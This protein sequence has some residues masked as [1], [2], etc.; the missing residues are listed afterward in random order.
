MLTEFQ[1]KIN[2]TSNAVAEVLLAES[3]ALPNIILL[4][5]LRGL[6]RDLIQQ[7]EASRRWC[8]HGLAL[9]FSTL[10]MPEQLSRATGIELTDMSII[11][12]LAYSILCQLTVDA[13][14]SR[15]RWRRMTDVVLIEFL[16][17]MSFSSS[18]FFTT[19][20]RTTTSRA[21][22]AVLRKGLEDWF[23]EA[24]SS[25]WDPTTL[26]RAIA[27]SLPV[28]QEFFV[29]ALKN[30]HG[31]ALEHQA[32]GASYW[33]GRLNAP[34]L[35]GNMTWFLL[36][37]L[38]ERFPPTVPSTSSDGA[39]DSTQ[40]FHRLASCQHLVGLND[41][42]LR[43]AGAELLQQM[44]Q[45]SAPSYA[46]SSA[47]QNWTFEKKMPSVSASLIRYLGKGLRFPETEQVLRE[48]LKGHRQDPDAFALTVQL[49]VEEA[50]RFPA[51]KKL[52]E[53]TLRFYQLG[54]I[55]SAVRS[56]DGQGKGS[57]PIDDLIEMM[58][59]ELRMSPK[60]LMELM[61]QGDELMNQGMLR[62][63]LERM[64]GHRNMCEG[65]GIDDCDA[66]V[67]NPLEVAS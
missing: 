52:L 20:L 23:N 42:G 54:A 4:S 55:V 32:K 8:F 19:W 51:G 3:D 2:T 26:E 50:E 22:R 53:K 61:S 59:E 7:P 40:V 49:V 57:S 12:L 33:H 64:V 1:P 48:M 18:K 13:V 15:G 10:L 62:G 25:I 6:Q 14:E 36:A 21:C 47:A 9:F 28:T 37:S 43:K 63:A 41:L 34:P 60:E 17:A 30:L 35:E 11:T 66:N 45:T 5:L 38:A 56:A 16:A 39:S 29:R 24:S 44:E 67:G 31:G 65:A 27:Q 58:P 46:L